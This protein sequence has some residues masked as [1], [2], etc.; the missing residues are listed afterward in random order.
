MFYLLH[1]PKKRL[2]DSSFNWDKWLTFYAFL[3]SIT[4]LNFARAIGD[5][6]TLLDVDL[7]LF[8]LNY[9]LEAQIHGTKHLRD[10]PPPIHTVN[11]K[12]LPEKD[13]LGWGFNVPNLEEWEALEQEVEDESNPNSRILPRK[14]LTL[15]VISTN[16]HHGTEDGS[17]GNGAEPQSRNQEDGNG[18]FRKPRRYLPK[19]KE[20]NIEGKKMVAD[21]IDTSQGQFDDNEENQN[22]EI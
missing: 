20:I 14:A 15:N 8:A 3:P 17:M 22:I 4:V 19:E 18:S 7:K 1:L 21:G 6:Q 16:H 10:S 13:M 11:F 2:R 5:L 12:R 9:T